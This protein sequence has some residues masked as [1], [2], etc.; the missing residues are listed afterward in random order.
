M[1]MKKKFKITWLFL[2]CFALMGC[3]AGHFHNYEYLGTELQSDHLNF[4]RIPFNNETDILI[5]TGYYFEFINQK[6]NGLTVIIKANPAFILN[7]KSIIKKVS[8]SLFGDFEKVVNLP[9]TARVH[10]TI[11]T[12]M[13][14]LALQTKNETRTLKLLTKDTIKIHLSNGKAL[15]FVKKA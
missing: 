14:N 6:E 4:A 1:F 12:L 7:E 15:H 10:D 11:N 3:P 2:I 9:Y 8:S 5:K 13:Y